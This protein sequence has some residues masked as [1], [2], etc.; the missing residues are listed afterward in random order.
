MKEFCLFSLFLLIENKK[1]LIF[2]KVKIFV[3][4]IL[5]MLLL[6]LICTTKKF[7]IK[8]DW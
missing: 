2:D 7:K 8:L 3:L 4:I 6:D 1:I 5:M